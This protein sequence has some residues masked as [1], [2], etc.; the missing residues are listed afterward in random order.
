M[1]RMRSHVVRP[2]RRTTGAI[3][4][5][6]CAAFFNSRG[7]NGSR[8]HASGRGRV[9]SQ[10]PE[11]GICHTT[12]RGRARRRGADR[13]A[14]MHR[15]LVGV[16]G[17]HCRGI[18]RALLA[19]RARVEFLFVL[20]LL[21]TVAVARQGFRDFLHCDAQLGY[22]YL[23][24]DRR[25]IAQLHGSDP[26]VHNNVPVH[27]SGRAAVVRALVARPRH[28]ELCVATRVRQLHEPEKRRERSVP[29]LRPRVQA[30]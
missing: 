13:A 27:E 24:S 18:E 20:E 23:R 16:R 10:A 29:R 14:R 17:T 2:T 9:R 28:G 15:K 5:A 26:V 30:G 3:C 4:T 11:I 1:Q 12:A 7:G 19:G 25:Q 6:V 21:E 8:W 22:G